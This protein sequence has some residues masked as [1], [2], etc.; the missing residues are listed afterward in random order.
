MLVFAYC[1]C[2]RCG[3]HYTGQV[4]SERLQECAGSKG[5]KPLKRECECCTWKVA[6]DHFRRQLEQIGPTDVGM[7]GSVIPYPS[8]LAQKE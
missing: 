5:P 2:P 3:K 7:D 6:G 8:A 4:D 1:R